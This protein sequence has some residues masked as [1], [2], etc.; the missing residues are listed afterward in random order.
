MIVTLLGVCIV[1]VGLMTL[2]W[3]QGHR[4]VRNI[5]CQ[6]CILDYLCDSDVYSGEIINMFFVGQMSR[7]VENM[8]IEIY[9][10]T[11]NVINV[12]LCMI[13][14][15]IELYLFIPLSV[16]LTI[17]RNGSHSSVKLF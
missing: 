2:T 5:N 1:I 4:C 15:L 3:F 7:L 17:F 12:K 14:L 16:T 11:I 9:S 10:D 6:L 8:N 13:V